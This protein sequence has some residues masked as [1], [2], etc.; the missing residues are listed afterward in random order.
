MFILSINEYSTGE[1]NAEV[2]PCDGLASY[3][4]NPTC[5]SWGR[6]KKNTPVYAGLQKLQRFRKCNFSYKPFHFQGK[7]CPCLDSTIL[8]KTKV[9]TIQMKP[10]Y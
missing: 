2:K 7:I 6:E 1:H 8:M 9:V 4:A 10:K 3:S 5:F